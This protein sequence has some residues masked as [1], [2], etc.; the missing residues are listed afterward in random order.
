[1][2]PEFLFQANLAINKPF[3]IYVKLNSLDYCS[4]LHELSGLQQ[5]S[6]FYELI[7]KYKK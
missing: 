6:L 1:M 7:Y 4:F 5:K 2:L 3:T